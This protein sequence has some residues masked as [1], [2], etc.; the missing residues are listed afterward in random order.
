MYAEA[1]LACG[2]MVLFFFCRFFF[3]LRGEKEP[4]KGKDQ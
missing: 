2:S 3:A 1:I 4:A